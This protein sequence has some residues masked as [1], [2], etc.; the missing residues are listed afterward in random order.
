MIFLFTGSFISTLLS[1]SVVTKIEYH[2]E[3]GDLTK[4]YII[5]RMLICSKI[6]KSI[7]LHLYVI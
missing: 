4:Y 6:C 5:T 2:P 7:H 3:G 1:S